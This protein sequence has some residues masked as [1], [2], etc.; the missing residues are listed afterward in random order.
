LFREFYK[1]I[2]NGSI[3]SSSSSFFF[4]GGNFVA[5]SFV[6]LAASNS[7]NQNAISPCTVEDVV[8]KGKINVFMFSKLLINNHFSIYILFALRYKYNYKMSF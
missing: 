7:K 4:L 2:S 1:A 6:E 3:G 5:L 8:K